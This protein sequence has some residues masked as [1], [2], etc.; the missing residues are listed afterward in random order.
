ME[1]LL[2]YVW[3]HKMFPLEPLATT[4]GQVIEVIDPGLPNRDAGPDFFNAKLKIDGVLWVG[5]VEI[6]A[7]ARDW[8][9]H[10]HHQDLLY[11]TVILHVVEEADAEI[12]RT[13]GQAIPQLVL[14]CPEEIRRRYEELKRTDFSPSCYEILPSLSKLAVHSWLSALQVE[15]FRQKAEV[16][17]ERLR[18]S[19]G[20]WEAAF[21]TTLARNFGFGLNGDAFEL[22][23]GRLN[24]TAVRKHRDNLMQ[25]EAFFFGQAGLL[26]ETIQDADEYYLQLQ[27]EYSYLVQKF[28]LQKPV[29]QQSWRMLRLRPGNF[30]HIRIAQLA[31]LFHHTEGLFSRIVEA[32]NTDAVRKLLRTKA[33]GYWR[34]HYTFNHVSEESEKHLG[35]NAMNLILIN[36]VIPL[37]Y[38]YGMHK[39][40]DMWCERATNF[41]ESLKAED[42]YIVRMWANVG[43]EINCAADSQALIQLKKEY[44]DKR[45]CLRCRFGYEYLRGRKSPSR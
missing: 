17:L 43:I 21:F 4:A 13:N 8:H 27:H 44:C 36:T 20:D 26:E 11:D 35:A 45:D 18:R 3:K 15:R 9:L 28:T 10:G 6:H 12:F 5:N 40:S 23:A 39:G 32:E 2:H 34:T 33:D 19:G 24:Y 41:L 30:P 7:R 14:K 38:A 37:L 31:Y 29:E 42:N 16:I 22:W 25:V 1:K